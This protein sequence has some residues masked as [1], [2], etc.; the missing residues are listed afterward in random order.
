MQLHRVPIGMLPNVLSQIEEILKVFHGMD[1]EMKQ[2]H[3]SLRESI[4]WTKIFKDSVLDIEKTYNVIVR[5]G[6]VARIEV[7]GIFGSACAVYWPPIVRK[8]S[9]NGLTTPCAER[10]KTKRPR[11][12]TWRDGI[13][14]WKPWKNVSGHCA[15]SFPAV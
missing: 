10:F 6:Q 12:G 5:P 4:C 15:K 11:L 2:K 7:I 1:N 13:L 3:T 14:R 9:R 8:G